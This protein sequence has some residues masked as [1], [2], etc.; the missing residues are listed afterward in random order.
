MAVASAVVE[1]I[2]AAHV[3]AAFGVLT[4]N[5]GLIGAFLPPERDPDTAAARPR[6]TEPV[7]Q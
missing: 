7:L 3:I 5:A 2:N 6:P 4:V 1:D